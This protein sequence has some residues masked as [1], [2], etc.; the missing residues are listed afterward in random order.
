[1]CDHKSRTAW[2]VSAALTLAGLAWTGS[3]L[4]QTREAMVWVTDGGLEELGRALAEQGLAVEQ[5]LAGAVGL[6]LGA[7]EIAALRASGLRVDELPDPTRLRLASGEQVD[8]AARP[9]D[10]RSLP[11]GDELWPL[12]VAMA[13][14]LTPER[15]EALGKTGAR[16][17]SPLPPSAYLVRASRAAAAGLARLPFVAAVA[18]VEPRWKVSPAFAGQTGGVLPVR[19][20]LYPGAEAELVLDFVR[21][22][23]KVLGEGS[24]IAGWMIGADLSVDLLDELGAFP[25]LATIEPASPGQ[26]F[27]NSIRVVMQTERQHLL[28]NQDF[29]NPIYGLGVFG[30]SQT[31]AISDSGLDSG[32]EQFAAGGAKVLGVV[33]VP[34]TLGAPCAPDGLDPFSHGTPVAN[35][36]AGDSAFSGTQFGTVG[37]RDGIAVGAKL[38]V[39]DITRD[40]GG[41]LDPVPCDYVSLPTSVLAPAYGQGARVHNLSWGHMSLPGFTQGIYNSVTL[42]LDQ[43]AYDH[44]DSVLV[45]AAGNTGGVWVWDYAL[46]YWYIQPIAATL[47]DEAHAKNVIAVGGSRDADNRHVMYGFSSRGPTTGEVVKVGSVPSTLCH[48]QGRLKPDLLAPGSTTIESAETSGGD[49]YCHGLNPTCPYGYFGTSHAAPAI[50]AS[51]A[52]I[53]DYFAQGKYPNDANDP[54]LENPANPSAALV[55]AML[56]NAAVFL[57]DETA[58]AASKLA[59]PSCGDTTYPNYDQ[60]FGR[61]AL[62][63]V[64]EPAGPRRVRL[65]DQAT[66]K[67][68]PAGLWTRQPAIKDKWNWACS[69]LRVTLAWTDPPKSLLG[70]KMLV[71]DLDLEVVYNGVTYRGNHGLTGDSG[72]ATPIWDQLNNVEDVFIPLG[73]QQLAQ[74]QPTIRVYGNAGNSGEQRFA[75][76]YSF[77][78]CLDN[79]PSN[80]TPVGGCYRGPGDTVPG[81][82]PPPVDGG[83]CQSQDYSYGECTACGQA[84]YP[85]FAP[86]PWIILPPC[87]QQPGELSPRAACRPVGF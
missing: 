18:P 39:Q 12:V 68:G 59:S 1:M 27:N 62:D 34:G 61:P 3:S 71:N 78:P 44:P 25:D 51:A 58:Y 46:K 29:Y 77:G 53:R 79:T 43:W 64:L 74:V 4:G 57:K 21:R 33:A 49:P 54:P 35:T 60:G 76:V 55:K 17:V 38:Y 28:G 9:F 85:P 6:R 14:V 84:P 75:L 67:V 24:T 47:S 50:S 52:L 30:A 11:D 41:G 32:H 83:T 22:H 86:A 48:E 45:F 82:H 65:Y 10:A 19:L 5:R 7:A 13:G 42:E 31:V 56:V 81:A 72:T 37:G 73:A 87:Q 70:G 69:V 20:L 80:V 2:W 8:L 23:G 16:L 36:L 26:L 66:I 15:L 40:P 63:N